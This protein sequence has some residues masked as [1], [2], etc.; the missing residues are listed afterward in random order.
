MGGGPDGWCTCLGPYSNRLE[1]KTEG[2]LQRK[3]KRILGSLCS[4]VVILGR[5][6]SRSRLDEVP[7]CEKGMI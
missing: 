4:K 6:S 7:N 3:R 5:C 2:P 1:C